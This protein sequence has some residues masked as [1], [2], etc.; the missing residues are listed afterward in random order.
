MLSDFVRIVSG[1]TF[2]PDGKILATNGSEDPKLWNAETGKQLFLLPGFKSGSAQG[3][4]FTPDGKYVAVAGQD[5]TVSIWET[6]T[7]GQYLTFATGTP[8]DGQIEFSP[9]C[10]APPTAPY[11]WCGVFLAT[12]NRDG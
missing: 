4:V 2:S 11:T 12:G 6:A 3:P 1:A 9:E 8:V 7:G 5:G 10:V